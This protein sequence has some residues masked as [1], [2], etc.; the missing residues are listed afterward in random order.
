MADTSAPPS[1]EE[2]YGIARNTSDL[3][4]A[5]GLVS[6]EGLV[7]KAADILMAAGMMAAKGRNPLG[8]ALGDLLAEWGSCSKP[9]KPSDALIAARAAQLKDRK[10]RPDLHRARAEAIVAYSREMRER[11]MRLHSRTKVMVLLTE[12]AVKRGVDVDLLSPALFHWLAPT[13]PVCDGTRKTAALWP[14]VGGTC[15]HCHGS[16]TW[17][18]PLGASAIHEHIADCI[19]KA[20][21]GMAGKLR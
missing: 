21:S 8:M 18:R 4:V 1:L 7:N 3:T 12:W 10:G 13:C 15:K 2:R 14:A 5:G 17:T 16:G 6:G 19:G 11:A 20:K 9:P